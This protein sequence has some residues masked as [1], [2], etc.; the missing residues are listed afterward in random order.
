[1]FCLVLASS[2][3]RW[4]SAF[5]T[6]CSDLPKPTP[7]ALRLLHR[8]FA[9]FGQFFVQRFPLLCAF[10]W[11][12][13]IVVEQ[14]LQDIQAPLRFARLQVQGFLGIHAF[15]RMCS[16]VADVPDG[17]QVFLN[18]RRQVCCQRIVNRPVQTVLG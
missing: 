2:L 15:L 6:F 11:L 8:L 17:I 4:A 7:D 3:S 18:I 13:V 14:R 10:G 5:I 16:E 12:Y 9:S 1:M